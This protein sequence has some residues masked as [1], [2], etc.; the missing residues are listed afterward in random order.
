M[1]YPFI[2]A[3]SLILKIILYLQWF[4]LGVVVFISVL[5]A[6]NSHFVDLNKL[7]GF[8]IQFSKINLSELNQQQ[9]DGANS[10]YLTN[11]EGRLHVPNTGK[12]FFF[13]RVILVFVD[14]IL[15]IVIIYLLQ[16]IFSNLKNGDF[17]VREN[18]IFIRKIAIIV[19]LLAVIPAI[20]NFI[21]NH[22]LT[23]N[24][25]IQ[26]ITFKASFNFDFTTTFL[27]LL[28]F[29][30]AQVFIKGAELKEDNDLTI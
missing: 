21:L 25:Y 13:F 7:T 1:N 19:L 3:L 2:K 28:I 27:A 30:I 9:T 10:V 5:V 20:V 17:F 14:T 15:N 18:G 11:G 4:F 29:V 16:K 22:Y 8:Q 24:I 6:T 12:R 26:G 23:N